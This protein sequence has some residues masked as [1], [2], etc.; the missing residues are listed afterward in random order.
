MLGLGSTC[1]LLIVLCICCVTGHQRIGLPSDTLHIADDNIE[2]S[3]RKI[4]TINAETLVKYNSGFTGLHH[5][6]KE[7]SA[8]THGVPKSVTA[9]LH[10]DHHTTLIVHW[11]GEGSDVI[12][13]LAKNSSELDRSD[14]YVS[15]DY[16]KTFTDVNPRMRVASTN[17]QAV[18]NKYYTVNKLN[19]HYL[20]TDLHSHCLFTTDD[21]CYTFTR[22]CGLL[23]KPRSIS[24]HPHNAA[25]MLGLDEESFLKQLYLSNDFGATWIPVLSNIKAF[26]WDFAGSNDTSRIYAQE[27]Q[28]WD[29]SQI[30]SISLASY[31]RSGLSDH[32]GGPPNMEVMLR[33]VVDFQVKG[34][35]IFATVAVVRHL[36]ILKVNCCYMD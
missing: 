24:V 26:Y 19:T 2:I 35:Y 22:H 32:K 6:R 17:A 29:K 3:G 11:A 20:F 4:F 7:R 27:E 8:D 10:N 15:Y 25:Y 28:S 16:G 33:N 13:A 5:L 14:L 36:L 12:I 23:F 30:L 1:Q 9:N 18:I 31:A 21:S 34:D